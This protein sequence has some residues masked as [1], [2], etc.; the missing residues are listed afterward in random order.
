MLGEVQPITVLAARPMITPPELHNNALEPYGSLM[1]ACL[2]G[3][4]GEVLA[5]SLLTI[6]P[7]I[8]VSELGWKAIVTVDSNRE[9]GEFVAEK[10]IDM[11]W[12]VRKELTRTH[13]QDPRS[14][15]NR[16]FEQGDPT[17][18]ADLGDA[19]NGGAMGDSTE[20]LRLALSSSTSGK[21]ALSIT[22][23][24]SVQSAYLKGVGQEIDLQL[25][26]GNTG[27]YN[28]STQVRA[29]IIEIS[30]SKILYTSPAA[31][32]VIDDPGPSALL[33]VI[34]Q[35]NLAIEIYIVIHSQPVRV[36]DP[37]IYVLFGLDL[38][39][40]DVFQAKSHVSFK[41]GFAPI[42]SEFVLAN[43]IGPT[44]ADFKSL[45][46]CRRPRPLFPFEDI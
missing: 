24:Q 25:G 35:L 12:Q 3:E 16:A 2:A 1:A 23:P 41:P 18:I 36:I 34:N 14:A 11:A 40:F 46:Y 31:Q 13:A 44:T 19:T 21:L 32:G 37:A 33:K 43:T 7:W 22:D 5:I 38:F 4:R 6:Q 30:T 20:I 10:I 17:V 9:L 39:E 29:K 26:F 45:N 8:D 28:E 42:T 27:D 15:F